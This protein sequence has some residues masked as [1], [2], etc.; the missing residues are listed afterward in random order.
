M[1][2]YVIYILI[3]VTVVSV[4]TGGIHLYR[5]AQKNKKEMAPFAVKDIPLTANPG[6]TLVVF[7]SLSGNTRDIAEKIQ[8][9]TNADLYEIMT[10]EPIEA[11]PAFYI[12]SR[13]QLKNKAY[14]A[15]KGEL[16]DFSSYDTI[17][18]GFP[19]WWYTIATPV[20]AFLEKADFQGKKVVPFSTQGSNVGTSFTDFAAKARNARLLESASF[21]NLPE[22]YSQAVDNK[23]TVWLNSLS[24]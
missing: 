21:N 2:R 7:Y 6:K 20:L 10:E 12:K 24:N 23:I 16:P 13:Q 14:P 17:F 11:S 15:L 5:V 22:K 18:V 9:K 4:L 19:V 1:L 3:A 8:A